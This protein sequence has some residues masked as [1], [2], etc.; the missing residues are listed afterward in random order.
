MTGPGIEQQIMSIGAGTA[1]RRQSM[2]KQAQQLMAKADWGRLTQMLED[3]R[4]LPTLGPQILELV[5]GGA[6]EGFSDGVAGAI[7][8]ACRQDALLQLISARVSDALAEAGIRA[9]VLKGPLLGEAIYGEPGRRL[10]SDIDLLVAEEQLHQAVKVVRGLGYATPTDHVGDRGLPL[11][12]FALVHERGELPPV[13][14]HWRIHWYESQFAR[15]R[16]LPPAGKSP[17][18]GWRPAPLD[19][20][21]ALLLFYARDGFLGLRHAADL[22]AWWDTFG[23]E[24][25]PAALEASTRAYPALERALLAAVKAAETT[26]GLPS[27]QIVGPGS[28]LSTRGRIAAR[29]ADAHPHAS[30]AQVYADMGLIDGLLAPPGGLRA[31]IRRQIAP[32]RDVIREDA[33]KAPGERAT[34]PLG[35]SVR[36]VGRFSWALARLLRPPRT[37]QIDS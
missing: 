1:A 21:T 6:P 24:L 25:E 9:A 7:E 13:E 14:V 4:L 20:L 34:S 35:H 3:R 11:L 27:E 36:V 17:V 5:D 37:V 23:T 12:H 31:F 26:V 28:K 16:L 2:R 19:E 10:S 30:N 8:T 15:D 29:L 32:P 33:R 22:G 18:H